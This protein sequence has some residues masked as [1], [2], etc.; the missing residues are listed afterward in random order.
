[1]ATVR[2]CSTPNNLAASGQRIHR[3]DV[4]EVFQEHQQKM[5]I[6]SGA[7]NLLLPW[8]VSFTVPSTNSTS[9]STAVWNLPGTPLVARRAASESNKIENGRR[10]PG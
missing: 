5:V 8:K 10:A 4:H 3:Q 1:M 6:A 9:I 7:M 2:R